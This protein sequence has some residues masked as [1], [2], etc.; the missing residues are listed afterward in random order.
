[1]CGVIKKC[2]KWYNTS[3]DCLKGAAPLE[4]NIYLYRSVPMGQHELVLACILDIMFITLSLATLVHTSVTWIRVTWVAWDFIVWRRCVFYLWRWPPACH[5]SCWRGSPPWLP[6]PA[7]WGNL[8]GTGLFPPHGWPSV[9][10]SWCPGLPGC[11]AHTEGQQWAA[12]GHFLGW[13]WGHESD[14][15]ITSQ[16]KTT[17]VLFKFNTQIT[18]YAPCH[19]RWCSMADIQLHTDSII[20]QHICKNNINTTV[21]STYRLVKKHT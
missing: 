1:M 13:A 10:H 21:K 20:L 8:A 11:V 3:W 16:T 4:G 5:W 2:Q 12:G 7:F 17:N 9:C 6:T 15:E 19:K 14:K 18:P